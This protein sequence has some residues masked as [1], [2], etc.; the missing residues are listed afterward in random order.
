MGTFITTRPCSDCG[1]SIPEARLRALPSASRC[2][3]CQEAAGDP[4]LLAHHWKVADAIAEASSLD[5]EMSHGNGRQT[6]E[7]W[8]RP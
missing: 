4:K 1:Q 3:A 2:R 5:D 8:I 6:G 7:G